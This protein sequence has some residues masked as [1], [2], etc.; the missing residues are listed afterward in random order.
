MRL[1]PGAVSGAPRDP[2]VKAQICWKSVDGMI[3][4]TR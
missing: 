1:K 3:G 2:P 4:L